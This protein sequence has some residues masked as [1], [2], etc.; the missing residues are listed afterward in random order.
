MQE[1]WEGTESQKHMEDLENKM[2]EYIF[3][4]AERQK[5]CPTCAKRFLAFT[6][7]DIKEAEKHSRENDAKMWIAKKELLNEK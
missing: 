1:V 2:E 3:S 7:T 4:C 5:D 6:T